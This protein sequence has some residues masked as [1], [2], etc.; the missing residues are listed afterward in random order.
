[1]VKAEPYNRIAERQDHRNGFYERDFATLMGV[2]AKK[3]IALYF[4]ILSFAA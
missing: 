2:I 4:S 1:L 3:L